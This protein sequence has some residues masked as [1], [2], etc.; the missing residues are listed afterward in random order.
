MAVD[1]LLVSALNCG[2]D[3]ALCGC[4]GYAPVVVGIVECAHFD[5]PKDR[6]DGIMLL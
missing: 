2:E 1:H 3:F 5:W 6:G 4:C